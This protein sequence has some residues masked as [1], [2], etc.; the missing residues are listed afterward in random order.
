MEV[1][2]T[3]GAGF[4]GSNLADH[5]LRRGDRVTI[6]DNLSRR[7]SDCNLE[8]LAERYGESLHFI[9]AD[10]RDYDA[11]RGALPADAARVY[12]MAGQVAVTTSVS[13]A[14]EDFEI[15]AL[16]TFNVVE[17]VRCVAPGAILFYASTNK[18]YGGMEDVRTAESETRHRFLDFTDGIPE[19][20]PLDFH[21]LRLLQGVWRP[22]R[23]RLC[24]HLRTANGRDASVVYLRHAATGRGR[25]GLGGAFLHRRALWA[26][27]HYLWRWQA[28][29]RR[30][31]DR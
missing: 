21:S 19:E 23:A 26:A 29:A 24:P 18:V 12:H 28:S 31:V 13:N 15:N 6:L 11:L 7:G 25:P 17:A 8:W 4:I 30:A 22:V 20:Y 16:G 3:G 10:I 1:F 9:R 27:D 5:H 2:I 14:R